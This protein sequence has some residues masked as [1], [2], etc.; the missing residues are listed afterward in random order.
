L[1]ALDGFRGLAALLVLVHHVSPYPAETWTA[2][3]SALEWLHAGWVGVDLFFVLSGYLI[4]GILL[5][6]RARPSYFRN[7]YARRALRIFPL[8]YGVLFAIFV[9]LP[10][11]IR[12]Y[13]LDASA[14]GR[15]LEVLAEFRE[16]Q[17]NQIWLWTYLS[18]FATAL[19]DV[20]W[21]SLSH[22]WSL[23]VEE[24][25]YLVWP[26]V[27]LLLGRRSLMVLCAAIVVLSPAVRLAAP[28]VGVD[29][30]ATYV[31]TPCRL[32]GLATGAFLA[33]AAR[34]PGG[35]S[36]WVPLGNW[37]GVAA[38][39]GIGW[40]FYQQG[41]AGHG[42]FFC[43]IGFTLLAVAFGALLASAVTA[44]PNGLTGRLFRSKSLR[45][46]GKYSYGI[47]VYNRLLVLPV[48][49]LVQ[50]EVIASRGGSPLLGILAMQAVGM[51]AS[52][53]IAMLSWHL[54]EAPF[55]KFKR[56]FS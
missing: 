55:L 45:T 54:Y 21:W 2:G 14:S 18:N 42:A 23:A 11:V 34:G 15:L 4:T 31:L 33:A 32:D 44:S 30:L 43:T 17:H 10:L 50:P 12:L 22:F 28:L 29:L 16:I 5:D 41:S 49:I 48:R 8:Y 20:Q 6:D 35:L 37:L 7:F 40:G 24:H 26:A 25:F 56:Y 13:G 46:L 3:L 27:V 51:A 38:A 36:A 52:V 47:Y 1:P 53:G 9:L 19:L 39:A